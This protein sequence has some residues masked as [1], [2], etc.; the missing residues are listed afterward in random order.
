MLTFLK[1]VSRVIL[2]L[3]IIISVFLGASREGRAMVKSALFVPQVFDIGIKPL[4]WFTPRPIVEQVNFPVPNHVGQGD[5]YRPPGDG[6]YAAVLLFL[7][8]N[9]AG[10]TDSRIVSLG[11]ALA[12]SNMVTLFYWSPLM[13]DDRMEPEDLGNLVA[14]FQFLTSLPYVD[15]TRVG[16]GGFCVGASFVIMAASEETIRNQVA[17]VNAFGPYFDMENLIK[18][19]SSKSTFYGDQV[20][21]WEPNHLTRKVYVQHLTQDLPISEQRALRAAFLDDRPLE[22]AVQGLSNEGRA[23]HSLLSGVPLRDTTAH[24]QQI[25]KNTQERIRHISPSNYLAGLKAPVLIMHDR[26][27]DLVP[28]NESRRLADAL[29]KRGNVR[30]TEYY[31][32]FSHVTPNLGSGLNVAVELLKFIRHLHSIMLQAT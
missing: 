30:H 26:N 8:V 16:M 5:L 4:E 23:V 29:L 13:R 24:L 7:G 28:A 2:V 3:L 12:R 20:H 1:M 6:P 11:E 10:S 31:D 15:P 21:P 14:A 19:I 22:L 25:G 18:A 32:I 9:P 27:D 17:F